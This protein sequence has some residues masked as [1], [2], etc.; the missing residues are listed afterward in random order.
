GFLMTTV[1]FLD[2]TPDPD[3]GQIREAL[4]GNLCRCTGYQGIVEAVRD[5]AQR[6][7]TAKRQRDN[8]TTR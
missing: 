7:K 1:A 5:A 6:L 3:D 2:E 4:A 8:A